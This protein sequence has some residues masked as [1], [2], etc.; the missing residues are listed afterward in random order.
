MVIK[1]LGH[2]SF[3]IRG[4]S[5][6]VIT[7]PFSEKSVGFRFPSTSSDIVTVSHQHEDHNCVNSVEGQPFVIDGPGEYE[8]KGIRIHGI[9]TFHDNQRG[10]QRGKNVMYFFHIDGVSLLHCGD[11]GHALTEEHVDIVEEVDILFVPVGGV[12]TID[13]KTAAE[14]VSRLGPRVT[15]PMHYNEKRLNQEVFGKLL[16]IED[17]L[18]EMGQED[19]KSQEK[20]VISKSKLPEET[21]VVVLK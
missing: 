18:S 16:R 7:D 19:V 14:I 20:L 5:G 10:V 15:V 2:S 6:T 13:A 8:V 9:S 3:R 21:E 17:F 12:Y 11:L 4:S 1:H